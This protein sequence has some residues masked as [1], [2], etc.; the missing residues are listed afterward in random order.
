[1]PIS[2]APLGTGRWNTVVSFHASTL[3]STI[4]AISPAKPAAGNAEIKS[5][6][7]PNWIATSA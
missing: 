6:I 1:M 5:A 2:S 7:Y 4:F 3:T